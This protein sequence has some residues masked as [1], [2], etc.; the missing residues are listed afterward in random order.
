MCSKCTQQ[1]SELQS[2]PA[3]AVWLEF[4]I[5]ILSPAADKSTT[6][7]LLDSEK[8][9]RIS[10]FSPA[11]AT[12]FILSQHS[13]GCETEFSVEIVE[14]DFISSWVCC[15]TKLW[16]ISGV[17]A[18]LLL[19]WC[20]FRILPCSAAE[21]DWFVPSSYWTVIRS[22]L[23]SITA[24]GNSRWPWVTSTRKLSSMFMFLGKMLEVIVK[25]RAGRFIFYLSSGRWFFD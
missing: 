25:G 24:A 7:V 6:W 1:C 21:I 9:E 10:K 18:R 4:G 5:L 14:V 13:K 11:F 15:G 17:I 2:P 3:A 19:Q 20:D 22:L 23:A 12:N 8:Q 16:T